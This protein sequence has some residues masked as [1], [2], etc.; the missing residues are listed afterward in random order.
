MP[1]TKV[2]SHEIQQNLVSDRER[3]NMRHRNPF[4]NR[5]PLSARKRRRAIAISPQ[6]QERVLSRLKINAQR[7]IAEGLKDKIAARVE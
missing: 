6:R 1:F 7:L 3:F 4:A 2:M 5:K